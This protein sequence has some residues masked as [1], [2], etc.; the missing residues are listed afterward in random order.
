[1]N[2]SASPALGRMRLI[3]NMSC[4]GEREPFEIVLHFLFA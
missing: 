4:D 2:F 3:K 1:M